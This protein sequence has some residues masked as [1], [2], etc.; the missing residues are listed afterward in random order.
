MAI[1][2][3]TKFKGDNEREYNDIVGD[4]EGQRHTK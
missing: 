2:G 1:K 4:R 3:G